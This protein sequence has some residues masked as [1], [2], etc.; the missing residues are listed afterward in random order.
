MCVPVCDIPP[1]I[2]I[3]KKNNMWEYLQ[4]FPFKTVTCVGMNALAKNY[5]FKKSVR[6]IPLESGFKKLT[7]N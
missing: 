6:E 4:E 5:P 3:P 2:P 1:G 7:Y